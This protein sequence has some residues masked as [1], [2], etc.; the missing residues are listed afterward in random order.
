MVRI[1]ICHSLNTTW[2]IAH[3]SYVESKIWHKWTYLCN[4]NRLTGTENILVVANGGRSGWELD[5]ESGISGCKLVHIEWRDN[6]ALLYSTG[7]HIPHLVKNHNEKGHEKEYICI[8]TE[9]NA[10]LHSRN[11]TIL[12]ITYTSE[13]QIKKMSF[14]YK[15]IRQ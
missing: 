14:L 4:R 12:Q 3:H 5:C 10:L 9:S 11:Y 13:K 7:N 2:Y 8:L 1:K 6:K 15:S